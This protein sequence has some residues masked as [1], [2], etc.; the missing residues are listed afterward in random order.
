MG[1]GTEFKKEGRVRIQQC[2]IQSVFPIRNKKETTQKRKIRTG[3]RGYF[4]F[5]NQN[6][7][8]EGVPSFSG[9]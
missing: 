8:G 2:P 5:V 3:E 7:E 6:K 1:G 9:Y 4:P